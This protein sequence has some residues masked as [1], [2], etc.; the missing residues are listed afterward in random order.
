M[1]MPL[2]VVGSQ[3]DVSCDMGSQHHRWTES[4]SPIR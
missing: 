4:A 2:S 3:G 1:L